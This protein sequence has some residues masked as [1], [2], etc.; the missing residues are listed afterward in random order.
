MI[1]SFLR[2]IALITSGP[3]VVCIPALASNIT[4]D[5]TLTGTGYNA[6]VV[7]GSGTITVSTTSNPDVDVVTGITGSYAGGYFSGTVSG[8]ISGT[9]TLTAPP[10]PYT[11]SNYSSDAYTLWDNLLYPNSSSVSYDA[12]Y[13][14]DVTQALFDGTGIDFS[15]SVPGS[16]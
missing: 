12:G 1:T 4:Y 3:F 11:L 16:S 8:L 5:Y 14:Q 13:Y 9:G 6:G 15:V 10:A 2:R 7:S